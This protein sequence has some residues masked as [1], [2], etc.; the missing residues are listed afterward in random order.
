MKENNNINTFSSKNCKYTVSNRM[1]LNTINKT[2]YYIELPTQ[3]GNKENWIVPKKDL[4]MSLK[5]VSAL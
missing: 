5:F 2:N 3:K 4:G 1:E